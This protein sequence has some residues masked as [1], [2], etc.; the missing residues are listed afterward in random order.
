MVEVQP[1][2]KFSNA[3]RIFA[4]DWKEM[5]YNRQLF[6]SVL[7]FPLIIAIGLP[8]M[9]MGTFLADGV[10]PVEI[11]AIFQVEIGGMMKLQ[12][13]L[14][15][16]IVCAMIAGD[17]LA[18]EKERKTAESLIVLPVT[19]KEIFVG[20]IFAA[21]IPALFYA[22][23][24]FAIMGILSNLLVLEPILAGASPII[25][26]DLA[27][28]VIA[29]VLSPVF[30]LVIVQVVVMISAR[31]SSTKSAQQVS[32]VF[33]MPIFALMFTSLTEPGIISDV[34]FLLALS[35]VLLGIAIVLANFGGKAIDKERF[36]AGLG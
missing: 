23:M 20:K 17:S 35:A 8:L 33:A 7:L 18:G 21:L 26:G 2:F 25:F 19:V 24:G 14:I 6:L 5:R 29:L 13:L 16:V 32:M 1:A 31:L 22:V 3:Q 15:P 4:K 11:Y 27:F 12:F 9:M 30:G 36:I 10:P 34:G 28:W